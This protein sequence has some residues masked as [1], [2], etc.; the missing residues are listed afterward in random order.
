LTLVDGRLAVIYVNADGQL[1]VP[2]WAAGTNDPLDDDGKVQPTFILDL[3]I[4]DAHEFAWMLEQAATR[5]DDA[6]LER[7]GEVSGGL[8]DN[9]LAAAA[10]IDVEFNGILPGRL[11]ELSEQLA[12][13]ATAWKM[14]LDAQLKDWK[15]LRLIKNDDPEA[16]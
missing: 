10:A 8:L 4:T 2:I 1:A 3:T 16:S 6:G 14:F 12:T 9:A 11:V 13:A 15:P 5:A 7:G